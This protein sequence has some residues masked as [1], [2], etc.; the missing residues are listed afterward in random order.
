MLPSA[1][2]G[3]HVLSKL[4]GGADLMLPGVVLPKAESSELTGV[5]KGQLCSISL[6]GNRYGTY[7]NVSINS[8]LIHEAMLDKKPSADT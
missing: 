3:P 5:E 2:T 6:V 1:S 4:Q 7:D 8:S